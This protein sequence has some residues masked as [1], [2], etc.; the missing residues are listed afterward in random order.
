MLATLSPLS[1]LWQP[2]VPF[3]DFEVF[4]EG[5][6]SGKQDLTVLGQST[7]VWSDLPR[8][9]LFSP[10][11]FLLT[12]LGHDS[13]HGVQL[14]DFAGRHGAAWGGGAGGGVPGHL[15]ARLHGGIGLEVRAMG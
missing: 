14:S 9:F 12:R 8:F 6:F 15:R 13:R 10:K 7:E 2:S 3:L 4:W 5:N 1:G 11:D